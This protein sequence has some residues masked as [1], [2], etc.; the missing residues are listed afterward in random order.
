MTEL[1]IHYLTSELVSHV[2]CG[3]KFTKE[4]ST[5]DPTAVTCR[6]CSRLMAPALDKL[7]VAVMAP[8]TPRVKFHKP[9]KIKVGSR[10]QMRATT[11]T[12]KHHALPN[13]YHH[14]IKVKVG[15]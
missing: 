11:K 8:R 12:L 9:R 5:M 10:V 1:R 15:A 3:N 2:M 4:N 13:N 14:K 7:M 6:N